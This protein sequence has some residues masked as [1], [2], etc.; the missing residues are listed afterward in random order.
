M[1]YYSAIKKKKVMPSAATWMQLEI[2]I[3]S[4]ISQKK[5]DKCVKV[6]NREITV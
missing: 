1:E 2:C 6:F 3:L 4:G 5:K